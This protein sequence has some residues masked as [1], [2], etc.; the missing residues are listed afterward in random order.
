[1]K[2]MINVFQPMLGE[3]ELAAVREVFESNW[4]GRGE[5]TKAFEE[6]FARHLGVGPRHV[7]S[8]NSC[9]EA[10]FIAM[11]L[12]GVGPGAEVVLP[13]ISFVGAGNAVASRGARPV[14]CDVD[15]RTLNPTADH[16]E[17]ALTPRT[18]AV[19]VLHYG[20]RPG[21]VARIAELCRE[22]GVLLVEDAAIA[23]ASRVDGRACGT[24]GDM[25]VWSF[26]HGKIL[27]TVDGGMLYVRDP[28][29]AARAPKLAYLG[30][31]QVSGYD[32]ALRAR[33][34]WW[35]FELSS[36]SR[37]SVTN[38]VLSA[39]GL[40]QLGRLPGFVARRRRI[41]ERY[42]RGL[43]GV[44][45]LL[46]PPPLPPGHESSHYMYWIQLEGGIRDDLARDLYE[47]GIYTT[48]R[49]PPLH[50][51]RAY[52]SDAVLPGADRAADGTLLLPM[53]QGLTDADVD[54][55]VDAVRECVRARLGRRRSPAPA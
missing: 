3:Q 2:D 35:E 15:P 13:T 9:T 40:V 7:T 51:V 25:G 26:D 5:R 32:Q 4:I 46:C 18:R 23:V 49:Y 39:V 20:G 52:G 28:E 41:A 11:E 44:E 37:R 50:R 38:D 53:H 17:A 8:T 12:A 33:T 34:R 29:L 54:R 21:D 24:F 45:G 36:F 10:T 27:V 42:D 43:A 47:R 19:V 31:E 30:M 6:G 1:M 14:F 55:V 22:R 16:V 48:F